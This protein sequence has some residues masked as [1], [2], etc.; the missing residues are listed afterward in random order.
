M[1]DAYGELGKRVGVTDEAQAAAPAGIVP[2][3]VLDGGPR[4]FEKP[5]GTG[6]ERFKGRLTSHGYSVA[7]AEAKA[8]NYAQRHEGRRRG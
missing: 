5:G 4:S 2:L 3:P 6:Y 1:G 7:E 8:A